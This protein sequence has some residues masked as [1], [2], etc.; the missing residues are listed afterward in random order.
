VPPPGIGSR[1]EG[2]V[3]RETNRHALLGILAIRQDHGSLIGA[4]DWEALKRR[5]GE[6]LLSCSEAMWERATRII[7]Q[8][9]V[10]TLDYLPDL[11]V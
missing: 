10:T 11:L 5:F 1:S 8:A 2:A 9:P 4:A 6:K 3:D 7:P